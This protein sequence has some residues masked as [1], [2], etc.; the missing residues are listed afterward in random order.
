[1]FEERLFRQLYEGLGS[2]RGLRRFGLPPGARR[3][4]TLSFRI[5]GKSADDIAVGLAKQGLFVSHGDFYAATV[6]SRLRE[7]GVG[8]DGVVRIGCSCYTTAEEIDRVVRAVA[9]L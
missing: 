4:P 5:E 2:V 8:D 6:I 1:M 7:L 3:T 9:G